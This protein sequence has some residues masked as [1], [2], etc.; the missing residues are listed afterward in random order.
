MHRYEG[1][2]S[3]CILIII[4]SVIIGFSLKFLLTFHWLITDLSYDPQRV[5]V[6]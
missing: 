5:K 4:K 3:E 6:R 1:W 2:T